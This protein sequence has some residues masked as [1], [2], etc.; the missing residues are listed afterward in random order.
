M[1]RTALTVAVPKGPHDRLLSVEVPGQPAGDNH[2]G[3][4]ERSMRKPM[5]S[6]RARV[7]CH[8]ALLIL[9]FIGHTRS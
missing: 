4:R 6:S 3:Q 5:F 7:H 2:Q 9:L 8:G 1:A